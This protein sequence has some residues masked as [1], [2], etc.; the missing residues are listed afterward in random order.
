M[1]GV[2]GG[3]VEVSGG[4]VR[5]SVRG[6]KGVRGVRGVRGSPH[7]PACGPGLGSVPQGTSWVW[8]I[9]GACLRQLVSQCEMIQNTEFG[10]KE[11]K[12]K[13]EF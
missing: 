5:G 11:L 3:S 8:G 7:A 10:A 2:S 4:S 13:G 12:W 9:P 1:S 6:V